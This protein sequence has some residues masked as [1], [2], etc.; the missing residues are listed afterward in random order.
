MKSLCEARSGSVLVSTACS[1]SL[2]LAPL[3]AEKASSAA[4]R[5]LVSPRAA[6]AQGLV[7]RLDLTASVETEAS[8]PDG[9]SY[10]FEIGDHSVT[11]P[12][13]QLSDDQRALAELLLGP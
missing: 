6:T 5:P 12:Q 7:D 10:T 3:T 4:G 13:Q 11:V 2:V 9:F 8:F 1:A